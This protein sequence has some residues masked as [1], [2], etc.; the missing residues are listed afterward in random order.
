MESDSG[1]NIS[2]KFQLIIDGCNGPIRFREDRLRRSTVTD[3][4][5]EES[6]EN[7]PEESGG[8]GDDDET[9][10]SLL[11]PESI[12]SDKQAKQQ[13][14][15]NG[16]TKSTKGRRK[17]NH[18]PKIFTDE[19]TAVCAEES[20][21][22]LD[23]IPLLEKLLLSSACNAQ[24]RNSVGIQLFDSISVVFD[25]ISITKRPPVPVS[26]SKGGNQQLLQRKDE[27]AEDEIVQGR[28]WHVTTDTSN[29]RATVRAHKA[30]IGNS[31]KDQLGFL[32]IE[33]TGIYDEAD[34]V[35]VERIQEHHRRTIDLERHPSI[36]VTKEAPESL[37]ALTRIQVLRRTERGAGKNRRL[38]QP[39]GLLRPESV[40]CVFEFGIPISTKGDNNC[41]EDQEE[42][43]SE[44]DKGCVLLSSTFSKLAH[45]GHQTL[46]S[47]RRHNPGNVFLA[48]DE[49]LEV[50]CTT[51]VE[52]GEPVILPIVATD[53]IF[54]RQRIIHE[55]G[56]VMTFH[57]LW[58][59]LV[60]VALQR[61]R[62]D[63]Q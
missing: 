12:R 58:L 38:F 52:R 43:T 50:P 39:L 37:T 2:Y 19:D 63:S 22:R 13:R 48:F 31:V 29:E 56:Y 7:D 8:G 26:N 25:G 61:N 44:Y 16:S 34:N 47:V 18:K 4:S 57:Q 51:G 60:D 10:L 27:T 33:I 49:P 42:H 5:K 30:D 15:K 28:L 55:G 17:Q 1:T 35:I 20:S 45:D 36:G 53:D 54:L 23:M 11:R 32:T 3:S 14:S 62:K 46:R 9:I 6:G 40:A 59:L 21:N 24:G 41:S